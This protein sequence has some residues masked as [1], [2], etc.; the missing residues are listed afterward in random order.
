MKKL[1]VL[2]SFLFF[3]GLVGGL[4]ANVT[5][6]AAQEQVINLDNA[7]ESAATDEASATDSAEAATASGVAQ[8]IQEQADNDITERTGP[9]RSRLTQYLTDNPPGTLSWHN[10]LQH[11]IYNAVTNGLSSNIVVLLILFPIITSVIAAF[12]HLI[13]L[14]GFGVYAPAVLSVALVSTG[15]GTG[16]VVFFIVL[17]AA[18]IFRS[19]TRRLKLQYLP[20][21]A[22]LLWGVSL[23]VLL[24]MIIS[25]LHEM[26]IFLAVSIFPLLIIMLLTENFME[27]Q[28]M[29]SQSQAVRLTV[30]TVL[31]AIVGSLIISSEVLQRTVILNPEATIIGVAIINILVGKYSGLRFLEYFRF[32]S[33][34][35]R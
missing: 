2:V 32:E 29:S 17:V 28:L 34:L 25:S 9:Q 24:L 4:A 13:G 1:S 26:T 14:R 10:F 16:L 21:T 31:I 27:T 33:I 19:L 5:T 11:A 22:M 18:L 12:R 15:I 6:V 35:E 7:T 3:I 8:Q 20:R 23:I 30:E